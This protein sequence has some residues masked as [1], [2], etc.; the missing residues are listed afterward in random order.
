MIQEKDINRHKKPR[1]TLFFYDNGSQLQSKYLFIDKFHMS[2]NSPVYKKRSAIYAYKKKK[3]K[4][5]K[6][7]H[8]KGGKCQCG[9]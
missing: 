2:E 5:Q 6:C 3:C 4:R 1:E 9:R 7:S 8:W